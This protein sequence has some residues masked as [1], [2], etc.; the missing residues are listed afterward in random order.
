[1]AAQPTHEVSV[2]PTQ[3][4]D[5][6]YQVRGGLCQARAPKDGII[7]AANVAEALKSGFKVG[8]NGP[9]AAE[10]L[11]RAPAPHTRARVQ[12]DCVLESF[13]RSCLGSS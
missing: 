3:V 11:P 7:P 4:L 1:M 13:R 2:Q 6:S 5:T 9:P 10:A 12:P 8:I